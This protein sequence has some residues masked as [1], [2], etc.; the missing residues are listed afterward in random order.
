[1][2]HGLFDCI[3][4]FYV[5]VALEAISE[6]L[7]GAGYGGTVKCVNFILLQKVEVRDGIAAQV[8]TIIATFPL[9]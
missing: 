7:L 1:M 9:Q 5:Q 4:Y 2:S 3:A 6:H 8:L